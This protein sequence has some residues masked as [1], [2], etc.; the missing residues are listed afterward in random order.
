MSTCTSLMRWRSLVCFLTLE[1]NARNGPHAVAAR[2]GVIAGRQPRVTA[3][4]GALLGMC[5]RDVMAARPASAV[6]RRFDEIWNGGNWAA[7][8][9]L[10]ARN[11]AS[12]ESV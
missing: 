12:H 3:A 1:K 8:D 6:R 7:V 9:E 11:H 2:V 10:Y 4:L 5:G